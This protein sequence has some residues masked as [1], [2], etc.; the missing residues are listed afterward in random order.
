MSFLSHLPLVGQV[1][2]FVRLA[3]GDKEG[4]MEALE[5]ATNTTSYIPV[6]G[7]IQCA[8]GALAGGPGNERVKRDFCRATGATAGICVGALAAP[9]A[10]SA[11]ASAG[12]AAGGVGSAAVVG[13]ASGA[14]GAVGGKV[15]QA[16]Y[17]HATRLK[18]REASNMTAGDYARCAAM[19]AAIGGVVGGGAQMYKNVESGKTAFGGARYDAYDSSAFDSGDQ[20]DIFAGKPGKPGMSNPSKGI[21]MK[22]AGKSNANFVNTDGSSIRGDGGV[23]DIY[24]MNDLPKRFQE[25]TGK[26]P[27][28]GNCSFCPNQ[29]DRILHVTERTARGKVGF[30]PGCASCNAWNNTSSPAY[31]GGQGAKVNGLLCWAADAPKK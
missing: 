31:S 6:L 3:C 24:G 11:A 1:E 7:H 4:G 30:T 18:N 13:S 15:Y 19:G 28:A 25:A 12:L 23:A 17:E 21:V 9:V 22:E 27:F 5:N 20:S 26:D 2:G 29:A 16:G 14:A 8:G 10:A